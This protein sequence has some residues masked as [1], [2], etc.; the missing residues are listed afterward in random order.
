MARLPRRHILHLTGISAVTAA[1]LALPL[2]PMA[3]TPPSPGPSSP[4]SP[5]PS[6]P[7][8]SPPGQ[9]PPDTTPSPPP[10]PADT[11]GTPSPSDT[12]GS[13]GSPG[14]GES[15][16]SAGD[17]TPDSQ[18]PKQQKKELDDAT[19][20]LEQK[21]AEVPGELAPS[22]E[23]LTATLRAVDAPGTPPQNRDAVIRTARSVSSALAVID[24]PGTPRA[25]RAQLTELVKQVAS[26][27]G[28][29]D[30]PG[31]RPE[32]RRAYFYAADKSANAYRLIDNPETPPAVAHAANR[33]IANL[34]R[35][36]QHDAKGKSFKEQSST[37]TGQEP[38]PAVL[39]LATVLAALGDQHS[40]DDG[41]RSSLAQ[42]AGEASSSLDGSND[43]GAS[44]DAQEQARQELQKQLTE[45]EKG[46][47]KY[48]SAQPLPSE[49][50]GKAAEVCTNAIFETASEGTLA[51]YLESVLPHTWNTAGVSDFWKS[52]EKGNDSLEIFTQLRNEHI[53][54]APMAIKQLVPK[55]ADSVP[56]S[57][58]FTAVGSSALHCLRAASQLDQNGIDSGTWVKMAEEQK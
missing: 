47:D 25:V 57:Q 15:P 46:F 29:A 12:G 26:T 33:I 52:E 19:K 21:K 43:P 23:Q 39:Q 56:A 7:G 28:A 17:D 22:V 55:L 36:A 6:T 20:V 30:S 31:I 49:Q 44:D 11:P 35:S 32:M 5:G 4:P 45:L 18:A 41:G 42:T 53:T 16:P 14:N 8:A 13:D 50:L 27:V 34:A 51:R 40:S 37:R 58:L 9:S 2:T 1:A 10:S 3:S 24:D 48:L 38:G 54:D